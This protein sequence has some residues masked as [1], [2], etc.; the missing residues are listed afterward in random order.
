MRYFILLI[1]FSISCSKEDNC[2]DTEPFFPLSSTYIRIQ[3]KEGKEYC[4]S[5]SELTKVTKFDYLKLEVGKEERIRIIC[6]ITK[7][8][9]ND[10]NKMKV[11]PHSPIY[12]I[13]DDISE[14][15]LDSVLN[16][17]FVRSGVMQLRKFPYEQRGDIIALGIKKGY[18]INFDD[19]RGEYY[20]S[21]K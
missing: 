1:L 10:F 12:E 14:A 18:R 4:I 3:S 6:G 21:S 20:W 13:S 8:D 2:G 16:L 5:Y 19:Y 7:L 17:A 9:T 11:D 15:N